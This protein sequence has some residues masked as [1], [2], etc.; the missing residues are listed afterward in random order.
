MVT[1]EDKEVLDRPITKE[2][3]YLALKVMQPLKT[4]GAM[5]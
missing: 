3:L 2:E 5:V 4:L 1:E